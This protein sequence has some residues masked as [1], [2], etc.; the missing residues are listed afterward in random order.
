MS[1]RIVFISDTHGLHRQLELPD[2]D[3]LIHGGDMTDYGELAV[4]E[5]FDAWLGELPHRH[6][7]V[8]AGN[9]DFC[10]EQQPVEAQRR[11]T[12][13]TYLQDEL[14]TVEGM[15]IYGSP[16]QPWFLNWAFNLHRGLDIK[17]K[18]DLIPDEVDLLVTHGPPFGLGDRT[19]TGND[20]G[21]RDLLAAAE[22]IRPRLHVYG[23]IHEG[24]GIFDVGGTRYMNASSCDTFCQYLRP[25][26]VID[27]DPV[28]GEMHAVTAE[29][30]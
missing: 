11:L 23:H 28:S 7:I 6:K 20:V 24:R 26:Y 30:S 27:F 4:V 1:K 13:A 5:D 12:Q 9:H 21:C 16:W 3:L 29:P 25:P 14:V 19:Y 18:W 8:I 15:R 10:F 2:G 17:A 22:R